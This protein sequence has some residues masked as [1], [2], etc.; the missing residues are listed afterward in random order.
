MMY[1]KLMSVFGLDSDGKFMGMNSMNITY[2]VIAVAVGLFIICV[3]MNL[4][5]RKTAPA[6]P[7]KKNSAAGI[8]AILSALPSLLPRCSPPASP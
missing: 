5:D 6:Y 3:L 7:V 2:A 4:F 8:F 1:L